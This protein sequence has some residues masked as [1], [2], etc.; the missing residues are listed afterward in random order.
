MHR[1]LAIA[2]GVTRAQGRKIIFT[3]NLPNVTDIDDALVRPGR[4][5]A[6]KN[7]RSLTPEEAERLAGR[8]CAGDGARFERVVGILRATASRA[9][10]LAQVYRAVG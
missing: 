2:D 7:L 6:V 4:C 8:L 3:T 5:H 10:S 9:H 1:F